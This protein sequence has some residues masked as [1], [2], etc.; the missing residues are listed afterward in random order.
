MPLSTYLPDLSALEL[1][2]DTARE[3]SIGAAARLQGISQQ[4]ASE[5]LRAVEAPVS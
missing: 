3:G 4:A 2:V 1:L 5:R